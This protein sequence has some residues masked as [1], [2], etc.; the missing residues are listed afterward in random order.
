M[1]GFSVIEMKIN[2][3]ILNLLFPPKC[4]NCSEFL[5]VRLTEKQIDPFCPSCRLHYENEKQRECKICGLSME[6]CRCMPKNMN[7]AQCTGLLK[8]I[9]YRPND[10]SMHIRR[11][12]YSIKH[13]DYKVSFDFVAEQMRKPLIAEMRASNLM[14][15]DCVITFLPRS[16]KNKAKDGFDQS[17]RLA[18]ALSQATGIELVNCFDRKIKTTE[19][20]KL[21]VY[22]RRLN[23][24]SAYKPR[25]VENQL[26]DKI[27]I[28]VDD[29][30]T[31]GSSM[32][33]C[34]RIAYS[35]GAYAVMGVC[36]GYT[37]KISKK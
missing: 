25:D 15:E 4:A 34:A 29:I 21:N 17:Y 37:E 26:K 10:E 22:E 33:A 32:A 5:D 27:V 36:L 2:N 19:Q 6:F 30:V 7:N 3:V 20:K 31:T 9:S 1:P 11:F 12:V 24:N 35:L 8:L 16:H 13:Y 18:K 28:L 14:P 23:M